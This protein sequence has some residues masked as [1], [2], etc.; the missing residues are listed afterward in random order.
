MMTGL[1]MHDLLA[2]SFCFIMRTTI[3]VAS[4]PS[5]SCGEFNRCFD[6][7]RDVVLLVYQLIL[8]Y[9]DVMPVQRRF[10]SVW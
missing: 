2:K 5:L 8:S 10:E 3:V 7:I 6:R 1:V 4:H 9:M